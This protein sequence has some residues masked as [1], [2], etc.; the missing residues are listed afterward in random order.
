MRRYTILRED[1]LADFRHKGTQETF[2]I[3]TL[4]GEEL[5]VLC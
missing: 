1:A 5:F 3:K 4:E 2:P